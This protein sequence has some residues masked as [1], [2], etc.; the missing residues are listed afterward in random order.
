MQGSF[1]DAWHG[2][3][4]LFFSEEYQFKTLDYESGIIVSEQIPLSGPLGEYAECEGVKSTFDA[5]L[6]S[7]MGE[8]TIIVQSQ[9]ESLQSIDISVKILQQ[10]EKTEW[11]NVIFDSVIA[12]LAGKKSVSEDESWRSGYWFECISNGGSEESMFRAAREN[13]RDY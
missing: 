11:D 13:V 7:V 6:G 3:V 1:N 9:S 4:E 12:G 8:Y 10:R 5:P 2:F